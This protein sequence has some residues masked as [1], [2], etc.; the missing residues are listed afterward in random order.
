MITDIT[1]KSFRTSKNL[2]FLSKG[3]LFKTNHTFET[4]QISDLKQKTHIILP[5]VI[6]IAM[7]G[8]RF[9]TDPEAV[10]QNTFD[11]YLFWGT[12]FF[13]IY[14]TWHVLWFLWDIRTEYSNPRFLGKLFLSL[15]GSVGVA[16]VIG[17]FNYWGLEFSDFKG[18][19]I[20]VLLFWIIQYTLRSQQS[21]AKLHLE[22]EQILTENFKT[23][24][25]VLHA[26]IDPHFL[27]NSMNTLRSMVRQSHENSEKF[28]LNL[29]D[30]Y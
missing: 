15:F 14:N 7:P 5:V 17:F 16:T 11:D 13:I 29:S 12:A 23:Q 28:I 26:K 27:F 3:Q 2:L 1:S 24:L 19:F 20:G 8:L 30:F 9:V 4:K 18:N 6:A 22:K 10:F 25:K 21:I